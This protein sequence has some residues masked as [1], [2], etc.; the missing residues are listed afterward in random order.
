MDKNE[1]I[2]MIKG[3]KFPSPTAAWQKINNE[4]IDMAIDALAAESGEQNEP[5]FVKANIMYNN[6]EFERIRYDLLKQNK[7]IVLLPYE[8][9]LVVNGYRPV[10]T[11]IKET[12]HYINDDDQ[13]EYYYTE[14]HC[15]N[16]GEEP[17]LNK[18]Y[19]NYLTP[20]CPW[21]GA[22]MEEE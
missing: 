22:R 5:I 19:I 14:Y 16:C 4:A 17:L 15:S 12:K 10:G 2:K 9:D 18:N 6:I 7:N 20:Y 3:L 1:A 8:V 11:W 21:C 13:E